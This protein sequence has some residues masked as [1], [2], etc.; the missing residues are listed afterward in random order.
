ME[1]NTLRDGLEIADEPLYFLSQCQEALD[2]AIEYL[3]DH[4]GLAAIV[5]RWGLTPA[6]TAEDQI[7]QL[8]ELISLEADKDPAERLYEILTV[9]SGPFRPWGALQ[10]LQPYVEVS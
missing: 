2:W 6:Q 5:S 9:R 10:G 4:K 8:H 1:F 7:V 3:A